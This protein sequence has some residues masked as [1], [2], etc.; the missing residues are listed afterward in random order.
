MN[1][2]CWIP[3]SGWHGLYEVSNFGH[4]KSL[5]NQ[6]STG[7]RNCVIRERILR[8]RHDKDG[9]LLVDLQNAGKKVTYKVHRLVAIAFIKNPKNKPQVNHKD[10]N[11]ENN[12]VNNLEWVTDSENKV[13]RYSELQKSKGDSGFY[14]VNWRADRGK[15]RAYLSVGGYTHLGLFAIKADAINAVQKARKKL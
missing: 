1:D 11:K 4:I 5:Q 9:Y 13:H 3:I 7:S 14:G 8:L 6:I 15:W 10:G 12:N 2:E